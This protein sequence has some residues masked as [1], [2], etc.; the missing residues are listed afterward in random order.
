MR[1]KNLKS[2]S[3]VTLLLSMGAN[4]DELTP[5]QNIRSITEHEEACLQT[6]APRATIFIEQLFAK[7]FNKE[8]FDQCIR[9]RLI[10]HGRAVLDYSHMID[11][12][13]DLNFRERQV[14]LEREMIETDN[15]EIGLPLKVREIRAT[16]PSTNVNLP[17]VDG[18][19]SVKSE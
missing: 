1:L 17:T 10:N 3:L 5:I 9:D 14:S 15:L 13:E 4:C 12:L 19:S 16:G 6:I 7:K 18:Y 8:K 11:R 2:I